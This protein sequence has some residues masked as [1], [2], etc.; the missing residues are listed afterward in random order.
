M[1]LTVTSGNRYIISIENKFSITELLPCVRQ[2]CDQNK[3]FLHEKVSISLDKWKALC[4]LMQYDIELMY[5]F[6]MIT[7]QFI[8][9]GWAS[10]ELPRNHVNVNLFLCHIWD[11]LR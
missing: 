11:L 7:F 5:T 10:A 1:T 2:F 8:C 6:G 9:H 4:I 3:V